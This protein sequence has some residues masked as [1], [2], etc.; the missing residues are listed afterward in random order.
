M[1]EKKSDATKTEK[2]YCVK[3]RQHV[4]VSNPQPVKM[5]SDRHA[6]QGLCP[7]CGTKTFKIVS[8]KSLS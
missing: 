5:G 6:L 4:I 1:P 8:K 7:H 2:M 3:C